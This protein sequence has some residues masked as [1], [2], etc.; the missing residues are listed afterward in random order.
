MK[1]WT[2]GPEAQG[3]RPQPMPL[4]E[5]RRT[6]RNVFVQLAAC[7]AFGISCLRP[8]ASL[9]AQIVPAQAG[10]VSCSDPAFSASAYCRGAG[11][12]AGQNATDPGSGYPNP[13]ATQPRS[14]D[15]YSRP[16]DQQQLYVDSAGTSDRRQRPPAAQ[17]EQTFLPDPITDFQKLARTATGEQLPIFG[18]DLFQRAPSTFAPAD[19]IPVTADYVVGPGDEILLRLWGPE[20]FNS[21]LTV[22]TAGSIFVPKVGAIQVAGLR[23]EE[24]Q[25]RISAEVSR[26]YRNYRIS[27]SLGHLRSIQVYV[28]GEA[29]RPGAYTISS[30][31]T[32]LNALFV[33]GGPNVQGSLRRI[34]VRREGQPSATF[35]LYDLVL[36]GD[37][38]KDLRLQQ[39]DTIF[40]PAT[41][42]QVALAGSVRHPGIYEL[43]STE[44]STLAEPRP[45]T[46]TIA[47]LLDYAGGLTPTA[48]VNSVSLERIDV[49]HS[50]RASTVALDTAGRSTAVRDGDVL[51][52]NHISP[53]YEQSVTLRG[54]LAN[55]GRFAWHAGMRLSEII[56]DR[57][58]LLTNDYW[59]ERNRL[60]VPVPLF[61]PA[62][63]QLNRYPAPDQQRAAGSPYG[64]NQ[65]RDQA[66]NG[67]DT[68]NNQAL[69]ADAAAL[70]LQ[71][72]QLPSSSNANQFLGAQAAANADPAY[73]GAVSSTRP[74]VSDS[75][76]Q[77]PTLPGS[78]SS[79]S[80]LTRM[81]HR[82][83]LP[84]AEIDWSYAVIERLDP[85][86]LKNT[87]LPFH[88]GALVQAHDPKQDLEL[89]AGD[90]VTILSQADIPVSL[91][92]QTKYVRLEG[93]FAS[94]GVYS[95]RPNETLDDLVRRA[96]GLSARAYLYGSSFLRESARV[97]QQQRLDEYISTL[98]VDMERSAAVRAASS[99]SGIF[100]P[101][102]IAEQRNLVAQLR[103]VRATGRVVLEFQPASGGTDAIPK[104]SLENGDVFRIPSR[105][106]T[107]SVIGAVY[108]QNVFLYNS[109]RR[110]ADYISLAGR[111]NRTADRSHAFIIRADGSIYS[112]E[113]A[114]G[115]LTNNFDGTR[116]N[117]GDAIV[118]PEKLI[119]PTALRTLL[120]YSQILSSFGLAAAAINVVR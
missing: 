89:Q 68:L 48:T 45:G 77:Q 2:N 111:P 79:T 72:S 27:V 92:E 105:P 3:A 70:A 19:Q 28:V 54:N 103:Q 49:D 88:L 98:A 116:I 30:L 69:R 59:R 6:V 60:G 113:R 4:R 5:A 86:T 51:F 7:A 34:Q 31:S 12:T 76:A 106:N 13:T 99:A 23:T 11:D 104:I 55:P 24:L 107:V 94:A 43:Q 64:S 109:D 10:Q 95:V 78:S 71:N 33:S 40:I 22:D 83:E 57:R 97:F 91:D 53:G 61:E 39:G 114:R 90:V 1:W 118:V 85:E 41:G 15:P 74:P 16:N 100:D 44:G 65:T 58:S 17:L 8:P 110:V 84:T 36:R 52:V 75:N 63:P 96:G 37:K 50:R 26:I 101:N 35:D 29:R 21:Q 42:P 93:E 87:L 119:K 46:T 56:P 112:R 117:P 82:I 20:S 80:R 32:V 67:E 9:A 66:L 62:E 81:Q 14:S 47:E 18:R 108:G 115:V 25:Q 120:D 73:P 38:S 102:S